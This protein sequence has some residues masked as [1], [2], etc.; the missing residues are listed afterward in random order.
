MNI[1]RISASKQPSTLLPLNSWFLILSSFSLS[2]GEA[3]RS[4]FEKDHY[5]Q[6]QHSKKNVVEVID[7]PE[8]YTEID[9][10]KYKSDKYKEKAP[11]DPETIK[12]RAKFLDADREMTKRKELAREELEARREWRREK[13]MTSVSPR[14]HKKGS[15]HKSHKRH[16]HTPE[17]SVIQLSE[18]EDDDKR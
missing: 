12:R 6:K 1:N 5:H 17:E 10:E 7:S 9:N 13:G 11:E 8:D 2:S 18:T 15:R 4:R 16:H 14:P 3:E